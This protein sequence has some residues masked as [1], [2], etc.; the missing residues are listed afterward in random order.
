MGE[1]NWPPRHPRCRRRGPGELRRDAPRVSCRPQ[2]ILPKACANRANGAQ[3]RTPLKQGRQG[4][5]DTVPPLCARRSTF[6]L[7]GSDDRCA[8]C[9]GTSA[10]DAKV[11]TFSS[12]RQGAPQ[13]RLLPCV[14]VSLPRAFV[15][16][17]LWSAGEG[18][19]SK[20]SIALQLRINLG[21]RLEPVLQRITGRSAAQGKVVGSLRNHP[22]TFLFC[23]LCGHR[24]GRRQRNFT[25]RRGCGGRR[26][27][28][29]RHRRTNSGVGLLLR[30]LR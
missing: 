28:R 2:R 22:V 23:H 4:Q 13:R 15:P 24:R 18:R 25:D 16:R 20:A 8:A 11:G 14:V 9:F 17:P 27:R 30:G 26:R 6:T 1:S 10:P 7:A 12:I 5:Q 19:R 3:Q 21:F 29:W